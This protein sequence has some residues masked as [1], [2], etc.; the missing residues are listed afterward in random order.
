MD[1]TKEALIRRINRKLPDSK[2]RRSR[3]GLYNLH[4][5]GQ[6]YRACVFTRAILETHIDLVTFAQNLM[7][8]P[9][10]E[11]INVM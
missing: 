4:Y 5:L 6:Y 3:P 1:I 2:V 9:R 8:V 10:N 7:V 11:T